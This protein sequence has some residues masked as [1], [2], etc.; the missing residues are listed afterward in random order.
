MSRKNISKVVKDAVII[1][2]DN[3]STKE[4]TKSFKQFM[5]DVPIKLFK[6][7]YNAGLWILA[8]VIMAFAFMA[9]VYTGVV[10]TS[11]IMGALGF[12]VGVTD[13]ITIMGAAVVIL[14][15]VGVLL[16]VYKL[17]A[18]IIYTKLIV[19]HSMRIERDPE[20]NKLKIIK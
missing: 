9:M 20:T 10:S 18:K 14:I 15:T 16:M 4:N 11:V 5:K 1:N 12:N 2:G 3:E 6:A 8:A 17:L 19:K 13:L 7:I